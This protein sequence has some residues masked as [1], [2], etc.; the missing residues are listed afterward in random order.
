METYLELE[1]F[2]SERL[3]QL[4]LEKRLELKAFESER[5]LL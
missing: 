5:L 2:E 1:A 4:K 3:V